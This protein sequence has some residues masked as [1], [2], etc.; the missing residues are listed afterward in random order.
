MFLAMTDGWHG[1]LRLEFDVRAGKTAIARQFARAPLKVQRPF[2][3][4]GAAVCHCPILHTAGGVVG[5]DRLDITVCLRPGARALLTTAAAGKI[6]RSN[7]REAQ[8]WVS[9]SL[10]AGAC[11][12]WLPQETILFDGARYRQQVRVDL[13]PDASWLGWDIARFG[14]TAR[15]EVFVQGKA[16]S[17]LEV[18]QDGQP[19]W[20]DRQCIAA[21]R[22]RDRGNG[23]GGY[24][25]VGSLVWI[26]QPV[27]TAE[28]A[29][30]RDGMAAVSPHGEAGITRLERGLSCRYRGHSSSAARLWFTEVWRSLRDRNAQPLVQV[31]RLWADPPRHS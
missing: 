30:L 18:W 31:P 15:G 1:E 20:I 28:I 12:E 22:D 13:A 26:G 8:Q 3:P 23:L 7:G 19:L 6:Y 5:G 11:L 4:E 9:I 29:M 27:G 25:V 17:W 10:A 24:P 2:Y 21:N 16:R 14:R